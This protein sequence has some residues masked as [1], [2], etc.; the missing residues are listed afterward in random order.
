MT[1]EY[2]VLIKHGCSEESSHVKQIS[3]LQVRMQQ[4]AVAR[5]TFLFFDGVATLLLVSLLLQ[6]RAVT[7]HQIF[8]K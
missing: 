2:S 8:Q 3:L 7:L 4:D 5:L 6:M 1:S